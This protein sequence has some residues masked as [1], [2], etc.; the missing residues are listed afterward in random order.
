MGILKIEVVEGTPDIFYANPYE[1]DVVF[2]SDPE[3][4]KAVGALDNCFIVGKGQEIKF[5]GAKCVYLSVP[6]G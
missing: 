4:L 1:Q 5:R 2:A 3:R 6:E